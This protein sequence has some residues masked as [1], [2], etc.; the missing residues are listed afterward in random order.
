M[1][2]IVETGRAVI[3]CAEKHYCRYY[4]MVISGYLTVRGQQDVHIIERG[5]TKKHPITTF[6]VFRNGILTSPKKE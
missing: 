6:A 3:M 4:R 1:I 2:R 5:R